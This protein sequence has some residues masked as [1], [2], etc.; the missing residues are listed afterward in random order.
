MGHVFVANMTGNIVFLGFTLLPGSGLSL[1]ASAAAI[2][3]FLVGAVLGGRLGVSMTH[4]TG[5]WLRTAFTA[6]ACLVA[7]VTLLAWLDVLVYSGDRALI[8][9]AVLAV[10]FGFQNATVRRLAAPDLTTTVVTLGLTGLAADSHLAGGTGG[11]P[12]RRLGSI[13]AMLAGAAAGALL[14]RV[15]TPTV[16]IALATVLVAAAA[17]L[18]S[19]TAGTA[20]S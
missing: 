6:Q 7:V 13:L 12:H 19:P 9:S 2:A 1:P 5:V 4:R 16:V 8:T 14:L 10:G 20:G 18:L 17:V 3:G 11:R 15:T